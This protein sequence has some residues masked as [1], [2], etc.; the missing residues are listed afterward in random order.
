MK[1]KIGVVLS[2]VCLAITLFS[3]CGKKEEPVKTQTETLP[4]FSSVLPSALAG[5]TMATGGK[6]CVDGLNKSKMDTIINI[7][8][9]DGFDINGWAYDNKTN[10][11]PETMFIELAPVKGGDKYYVAAKRSE[12][13]DLAVT[14]NKPAL[15]NAAFIQK[16]DIKSV[17]SGEYE[18]NIV[19]IADG[20]PIMT[21][22]GTKINKTN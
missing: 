18:I 14:F 1:M 7:K 10:T 9:E 15:K 19:Q 11:P 21:P 12:R 8:N 20:N 3:G 2:I 13:E 6:A 4:A 16:A 17:P 5:K 22:T